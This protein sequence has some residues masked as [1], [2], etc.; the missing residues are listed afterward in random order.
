M[1]KKRRLLWKR[2]IV[3]FMSFTLGIGFLYAYFGT[4]IFAIRSYEIEGAPEEYVEQLRNGMNLLAEQKLFYSLPGNRVISFHDDEIRT[5]IEETLTN[6]KKI[7]IYPKSLHT[8][9]VGIQSYTPLFSVSDTHAITED[10]VVYKEITSL[11]GYPRLHVG[12]STEVM[13]GTFRSLSKLVKNISSVLFP[14]EYIDISD[15][16]DIRLYDKDRK[17]A[18]LLSSSSDMDK[19]WSN[20][21]SAIDTEPLK[22]KLSGKGSYLEYL[23]TRFGNKVF[24]KF[25]NGEVPAIIPNTNATTTATTTVQ[26]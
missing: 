10:G 22:G 1:K 17:S 26:Q 6:T 25:T 11:A 21:L 16:N 8:L 9:H 15:D 7:R 5:L 13:R 24:Y 12:S 14:I 4:G 3:W 20:V 23:D 19:V 2:I 18:I